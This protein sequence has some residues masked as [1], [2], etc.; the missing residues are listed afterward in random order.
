MPFALLMHKLERLAFVE[1]R[2]DLDGKMLVLVR[3]PRL[4]VQDEQEAVCEAPLLGIGRDCEFRHLVSQQTRPL[5][6]ATRCVQ[7]VMA[8]S[9]RPKRQSLVQ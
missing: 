2:L 9:E 1:R 6:G 8:W 3:F 4:S 5:L 7:V